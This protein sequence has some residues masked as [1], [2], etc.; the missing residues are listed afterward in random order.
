MS[1]ELQQNKTDEKLV[2]L[3]NLLARGL[4][5]DIAEIGPDRFVSVLMDALRESGL[6]IADY[7]VPEEGKA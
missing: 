6:V 1:I 7:V 4:G 5:V 3:C 2:A